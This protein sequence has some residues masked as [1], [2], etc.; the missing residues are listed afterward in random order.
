MPKRKQAP[1]QPWEKVNPMEGRS[2][3]KFQSEFTCDP[4]YLNTQPFNK[5]TYKF[6]LPFT[7]PTLDILQTPIYLPVPMGAFKQFSQQQLQMQGY[8]NPM[9]H[10]HLHTQSSFQKPQEQLSNPFQRPQQLPQHQTS[11]REHPFGTQHPF[12]K[13]KNKKQKQK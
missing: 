3:K 13:N 6:P 2:S 5:Q 4:K 9:L 10:Q 1:S 7:T 11:S 8:L 12:N